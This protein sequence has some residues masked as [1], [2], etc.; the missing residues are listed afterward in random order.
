M[1]DCPNVDGTQVCQNPLPGVAR[2]FLGLSGATPGPVLVVCAA[3]R[4]ITVCRDGALTHDVHGGSGADTEQ[5]RAG[6]RFLSK[7]HTPASITVQLDDFA[8]ALRAVRVV[9]DPSLSRAS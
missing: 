7:L 2:T 6:I 3:C 8:I 4:F 1:Y 9:D 5:G